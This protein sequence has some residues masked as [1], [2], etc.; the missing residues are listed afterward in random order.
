[1]AA[2]WGVR[3]DAEGLEDAMEKHPAVRSSYVL[4][5]QFFDPGGW[6]LQNMLCLA[7]LM[8]E[9]ALKRQETRGCHVR[10]D[11]PEPNEMWCRHQT[12]RRGG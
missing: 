7:R 1:M 3:R 6:E 4:R 10:V 9:A 12:F 5:E 8:I 2:T 11:F